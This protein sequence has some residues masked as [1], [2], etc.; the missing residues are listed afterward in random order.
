M[1]AREVR[2]SV[3]IPRRARLRVKIHTS[4]GVVGPGKIELLRL[5]EEAGA[6]SAAARRMGMSF[7]RAW[8]LIDTMNA[9][10][11]RPVVETAVGGAGGGGARLTGFGREVITRYDEMMAKIDAEGAAFLDWLEVEEASGRDEPEV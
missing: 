4:S 8:H 6:I 3:D 5:I 10:L 7:R 2:K 9:A 11:G 1:S